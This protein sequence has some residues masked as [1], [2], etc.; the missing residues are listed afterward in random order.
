M[1]TRYLASSIL[2]YQSKE[3]IEYV[4]LANYLFPNDVIVAAR[5]LYKDTQ[6]WIERWDDEK[7]QYDEVLLAGYDGW[8]GRGALTEA[9][10][11]GKARIL[12]TTCITAHPFMLTNEIGN[13]FTRFRK[14]MY[15]CKA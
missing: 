12:C 4:R 3:Y 2:L 7:S 6:D 10:D 5:G 13:D 8:I 15:S 11:I 9:Q 14:L 1:A